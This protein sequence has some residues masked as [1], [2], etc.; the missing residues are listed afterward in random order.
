MRPFSLITP[1]IAIDSGAAGWKKYS[2]TQLGFAVDFP[3]DPSLSTGR[4]HTALA[5]SATAHIFSVKDARAA[6]VVTVVDLQD[7]REEGAILLGEAESLLTQ[8]GDV[9]SIS[10]SRAGGE[11]LVYGRRLTIECRGTRATD[12][13]SPT[14]EDSLLWFAEITGVECSEHGRLLTN[15]FFHEDRLY[16]V[17]A[18]PLQ[19]DDDLAAALRFA[20][21]VRFLAAS[22][23]R[24]RNPS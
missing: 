12:P 1:S 10:M 24:E 7:S 22:S 3:A 21:S 8:L 5:R 23:S 17:Q 9:R 20:G 2:E 11:R 19:Y 15:M 4:Y 16:L 14:L 13:V 6:Y 18:I